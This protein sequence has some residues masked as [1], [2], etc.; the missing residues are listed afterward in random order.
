[1]PLTDT[2]IKRAPK[3]DKQYQLRDQK[4]LYILVMPNGS[5]LW[6]F[7][8]KFEDKRRSMSFGSY[9]T[10]SLAKAREKQQAARVVI[11]E[12]RDPVREAQREADRIRKD[13]ETFKD[14]ARDYLDTLKEE[15]RADATL[16]KNEWLLMD[17]ARDLHRLPVREISAADILPI[18]QRLEKLG[19]VESATRL[20]GTIGSVFRFGIPRQRADVD[21]TYALRGA[22]RSKQTESH[23]AIIEEEP[24]GG[25]LRSVWN[26]D[27]WPTLVAGLKILAYCYPRPVE[28]RKCEWSHVD[29]ERQVWTVPDYLAKMRRPHDIP[30]PRQAVEIF[31]Y[32]KEVS[33]GSP[34]PFFAIRS[35]QRF[36]SENAFNSALRAMGYKHE[37]H[38]SHGF[39][40]SASTILRKHKFDNDVIEKSL[41]HIEPNESRR[42]Y[43]RYKYWDERV[44]LAQ[45]WA[46]IC[47]RLRTTPPA[48]L[49]SKRAFKRARDIENLI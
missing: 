8:F 19:K 2:V 47:D 28:L 30:L 22:I 34:Y 39:R 46:D 21:P 33:D 36:L 26:Y 16:N 9:P 35:N 29:L 32:L 41:A 37:D 45:A 18:L 23:P 15:G 38:V 49:Q 6:R 11:E 5:K 31:E 40:S 4:G 10:V 17:L 7:D 3:K 44:E 24:F 25:L 43:D 13:T 14:L 42:A 12:G 27:G 1:M 48:G 20:R